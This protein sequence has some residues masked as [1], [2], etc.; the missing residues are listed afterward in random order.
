MDEDVEVPEVG[1]FDRSLQSIVVA[2]GRRRTI[3]VNLAC[4]DVVFGVTYA[5]DLVFSV[6]QATMLG[7]DR[8]VAGQLTA[9]AMANVSVGR[10]WIICASRL[11]S[12]I[13]I[14]AMEVNQ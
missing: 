1:D 8:S 12:R 13:M 2:T 9:F 11:R 6:S 4:I 14:P 10:V 7:Q 5:Q 3:F